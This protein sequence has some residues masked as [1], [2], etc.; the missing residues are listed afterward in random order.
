LGEVE[1][2]GIST[3]YPA[4]TWDL[5]GGCMQDPGVSRRCGTPKLD[6]RSCPPKTF[7]ELKPA[8]LHLRLAWDDSVYGSGSIDT[9]LE[10]I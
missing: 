2:A 4:A 1:L 6:S 8:T 9:G 3:G 7:P 10:E 5:G